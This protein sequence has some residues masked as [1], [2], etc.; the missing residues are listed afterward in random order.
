MGWEDG[1][2]KVSWRVKL[3]NRP[4]PPGREEYFK[5]PEYPVKSGKNSKNPG[6]P[7]LANTFVC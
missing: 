6:H 3:R 7:R 1:V 5:T 4:G 2:I